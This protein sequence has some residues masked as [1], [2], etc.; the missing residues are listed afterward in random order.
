VAALFINYKVTQTSQCFQTLFFLFSAIVSPH[1]NEKT[2]FDLY[3]RGTRPPVFVPTDATR[4]LM[5]RDADED[6]GRQ[7]ILAEWCMAKTSPAGC[8]F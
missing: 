6:I 1:V 4:R 8:E 5:R 2:N 7:E 3:R